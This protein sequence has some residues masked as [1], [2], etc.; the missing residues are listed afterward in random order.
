MEAYSL[1]PYHKVYYKK[2]QKQKITGSSEIAPLLAFTRK[3]GGQ[4]KV[5]RPQGAGDAFYGTVADSI[6]RR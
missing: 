2:H 1:P 3:Q 5:Y 4:Q 6:L